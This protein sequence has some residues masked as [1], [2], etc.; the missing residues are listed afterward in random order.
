[1]REGENGESSQEMATFFG[2][3]PLSD[4]LLP[5]ATP[6]KVIGSSSQPEPGMN[7]FLNCFLW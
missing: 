5:L 3:D 1:M 2:G 7:R 6:S 4:Q